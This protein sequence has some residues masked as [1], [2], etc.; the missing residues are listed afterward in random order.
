MKTDEELTHLIIEEGTMII[1]KIGELP[2][3]TDLC[4]VKINPHLE[5]LASRYDQKSCL[6][7]EP[8]TQ[9]SQSS[10]HGS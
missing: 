6:S 9:V 7:E 2:D 4:N 8:S 3:G 1:T 5:E 10:Q